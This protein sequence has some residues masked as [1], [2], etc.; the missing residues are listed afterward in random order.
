MAVSDWSGTALPR[1][2][3]LATLKGRIGGLFRRA[4]PRRQ[5]G[6]L[7]EGLIGG[8]ERKDGRQLAEYADDPAPWRIQALLGR[9]LWV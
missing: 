7:L 4:E 6:L 3:E 5:I 2:E 8:A 9:T 1:A